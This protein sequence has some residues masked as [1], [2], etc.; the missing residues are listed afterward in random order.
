VGIGVRTAAARAEE[1]E[2]VAGSEATKE[3][4][5]LRML[6]EHLGF[7][8]PRPTDI[9]VDNKGAIT[10]GLHPANKPATRHVNMRMHAQPRVQEHRCKGGSGVQR[11]RGS[12][13]DFS[14]A[15]C[16]AHCYPRI[17]AASRL[18][19]SPTPPACRMRMVPDMGGGTT[20]APSRS[21]SLSLARA[22]SLSRSLARS[23]ALSLS[24]SQDCQEWCASQTFLTGQSL[25]GQPP[26]Y[27][28]LPA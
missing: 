12:P 5:N 28:G 3:A 22:L 13:H 23:R 26:P 9:Y 4:L 25:Q 24:L 7:G 27:H 16:S 6:L 1:S 14:S 20:L 10:M 18:L 8:G 21:L 19:P 15:S 17:P 11:D 2:Y